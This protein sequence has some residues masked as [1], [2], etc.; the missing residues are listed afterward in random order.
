MPDLELD[1]RDRVARITF[2]RP[3]KRNAFTAEMWQ[4][5]IDTADDLG[6]REDVDVVVLQ[7]SGGSFS[8]GADLNSVRDESGQESTTYRALAEGGIRAV[9]N[10]PLPTVALID[11]PCLGAGC[12]LALVCDV[13]FATPTASFAVPAVQYGLEVESTGLNRLVELVGPG[14]ATRF[15]LGGEKWDARQAAT[16]ALV[17][18]SDPNAPELVDAYARAV[19][20]ADRRA[21][22]AT[23]R[24]IRSAVQNAKSR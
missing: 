12:L 17:E 22:A 11:G 18:A 16:H 10:L 8:A 6:A 14:Q 7:G 1:V 21:A 23:R 20:S 24:A 13:R 5:L 15:L 9:A 3:E 2:N 19:V 4:M